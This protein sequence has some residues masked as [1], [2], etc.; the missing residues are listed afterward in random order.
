MGDSLLFEGRTRSKLTLPEASIE[1]SRSPLKNARLAVRNRSRLELEEGSE[2]RV[3]D[4]AE[5][6][7]MN[8][9][10]KKL[11]DKRSPS[12]S[13]STDWPRLKRFKSSPKGS[14]V[15]ANIASKPAH[16]RHLSDSTLIVAKTRRKRSATT[17]KPKSSSSSTTRRQ[18]PAVLPPQKERARSVPVFPS[19]RDFPVI[20]INDI[21]TSPTRRRPPT[22]EPKLRITSGSLFPQ[23]QTL[24]SIP[25]ET[26]EEQEATV[27]AARGVVAEIS[28]DAPL[29]ATPRQTDVLA[30]PADIH[31][32]PLTPLT[33][34]PETPFFK[35]VTENVDNTEDRFT[36]SDEGGALF[37]KEKLK[38]ASETTSIEAVVPAKDTRSR[39]PRPT[40]AT[41]SSSKTNLKG[42]VP[43]K[44]TSSRPTAL[45]GQETNAFDVLMGR[46]GKTKAKEKKSTDMAETSMHLS[47]VNVDKTT[48]FGKVT[49]QKK[50]SDMKGKGKNGANVEAKS[51]ST[52]TIIGKMRPRTKPDV[53]KPAVP[54]IFLEDEGEDVP[55]ELSNVGKIPGSPAYPL[56]PLPTR[57]SP[58][59]VEFGAFPPKSSSPDIEERLI[60]VD[61]AILTMDDVEMKG[62]DEITVERQPAIDTNVEPR[63]PSPLFSEPPTTAPSPLFSEPGHREDEYPKDGAYDEHVDTTNKP[64][65][66]ARIYNEPIEIEPPSHTLSTLEVRSS[67][68]LE[69]N[70]R[71]R[72][73]KVARPPLP[74]RTTRSASSKVP[75]KESTT[76][77]RTKKV[78]VS[79]KAG[80]KAANKAVAS[81]EVEVASSAVASSS[82]TDLPGLKEPPAY[83]DISKPQTLPVF[84]DDGEPLSELSD[85][86]EDYLDVELPLKGDGGEDVEM[87]AP[88]NTAEFDVAFTKSRMK[89]SS[90]EKLSIRLSPKRKL[91][92]GLKSEEAA[93]EGPSASFSVVSPP[94]PS[95]SSKAPLS[96]R[97]TRSSKKSAIPVPITPA[98]P[99]ASIFKSPAAPSIKPSSAPSSPTKLT[100]SYSM[101][102]YVPVMPHL[103][104]SDTSVLGR[105][106]HAL[107]ALSK[108]PPAWE[109]TRSKTS[110]GFNRDD[111]DSSIEFE[112]GSMDGVLEKGKKKSI[113]TVGLGRPSTSK[114]STTS[115][116]GHASN[117]KPASSMSSSSSVLGKSKMSQFLPVGTGP[118]LK[119]NKTA[120]VM[121]GGRLGMPMQPGTGNRFPVGPG[122]LGSRGKKASQRTTLPSVVASPVKGGGSVHE[123]NDVEMSDGEATRLDISM[124][125]NQ[126]DMDISE[127]EAIG[128]GIRDGKA[129]ETGNSLTMNRHPVALSQSMSALPNTTTM[130]LMG[131]PPP[132]ISP[133]R[134][135][136]L[137]S[138]SSSYPSSGNASQPQAPP[139]FV[140]ELTV[141]EGCTVFVDVWMSDGQDTSSLYIDIA[142]NLGARVVKRI[143]PQCTHVVYTSGRERTVDQYFALD[144]AK[145]PKAVGASWLRDCKQA[146]ARL[147]EERYLVD[148]E[149]HKPDPTSNIFSLKG[150]KDKRHKR[151][152]SYIPKFCGTDDNGTEDGDISIDESNTSM[153]DDEMTPLERARLRQS[154]AGSSSSHK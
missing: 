150:D 39:L 71:T 5:E 139:K 118:G 46:S 8:L 29:P 82:S 114:A 80:K 85:L 10:P 89:A 72:R 73:Q 125:G 121:R 75:T 35:K 105:L 7:E 3:E 31:A 136:G 123:G 21:P 153:V 52:S 144:E 127:L 47:G 53:K 87:E 77:G 45:R 142:K 152:Q 154:T 124:S 1:L 97:S 62:V 132:P 67:P 88:L 66:T 40:N 93:P 138:S 84:T 133:P 51:G 83:V 129:R 109:P 107:A 98:R 106:D 56:Q 104:N 54:H 92:R 26:G 34:L 43:L 86:P 141:L 38:A 69:I 41:A 76:S 95:S 126:S 18:S 42:L 131:P 140:P 120:A 4:S 17:S 128:G 64:D 99:K 65:G 68:S 27:G 102:S 15:E 9:S 57:N 110:M 111:P 149:E 13:T 115:S 20:D 119:K 24:E 36:A 113:S 33:P 78:L 101:F 117:S 94:S 12:P 116:N 50:G 137:R 63:V 90:D 32:V 145:R 55:G 25:D 23:S 135:A 108:P 11:G 79:R 28:V 2:A 143:G 112:A 100:K 148:L 19:F 81:S 49:K 151:R 44:A 70:S 74:P 58:S 134:R 14:D 22:W 122:S 16:S 147:D 37:R 48:E 60:G 103:I 6:D 146:A 91:P 130:E 61:E 59:P 96:V 30:V